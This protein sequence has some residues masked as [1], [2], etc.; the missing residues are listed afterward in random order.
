MEKT[1]MMYV[2][3]AKEFQLGS[4]AAGLSVELDLTKLKE[5]ASGPAADLVRTWTDRSGQEHRS[6]RLSIFPSKP[7]YVTEYATHSVQI[8]T[9][10][11]KVEPK[12]LPAADQAPA[13]TWAEEPADED[14]DLPF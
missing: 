6:I 3:K 14:S 2:G 11:S 5:Y 4:G 1:S 7:E 8:N 12:P 10:R 9:Y 13:K